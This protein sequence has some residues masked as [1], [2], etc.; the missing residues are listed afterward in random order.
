MT[1]PVHFHHMCSCNSPS[2]P[3]RQRPK[4]AVTM[5]ILQSGMPLC[6]I[7][8]S[9]LACSNNARVNSLCDACSRPAQLLAASDKKLKSKLHF[10]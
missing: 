10:R 9:S 2:C 4:R 1:R 8:N 6:M 3:M 7:G 5:E